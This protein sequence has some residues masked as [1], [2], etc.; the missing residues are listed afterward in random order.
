MSEMRSGSERR[1]KPTPFFNRYLLKGRRKEH[2][3]SEDLKQNIYVD[4]FNSIEWFAI[5]LL[6]LLCAA[7]AFL[8]IV[9]LGNGFQEIN[10]ILDGAYQYGGPAWFLITKFGITLPGIVFVL[11]HVKTTIAQKA[12]KLLVAVYSVVVVYQLTPW[13]L[14]SFWIT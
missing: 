6:L 14:S 5:S 2:R 4:R 9:H 12:I 11:I 13:F 10:P 3:R 8:T 1:L 7:D